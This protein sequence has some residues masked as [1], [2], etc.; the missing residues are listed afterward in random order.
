M[1]GRKREVFVYGAI[2]LYCLCAYSFVT[3]RTPEQHLSLDSLAFALHN[4]IQTILWDRL[5]EKL[6]M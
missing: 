6:A 1:S 3:Y 4:K 5:F 2:L